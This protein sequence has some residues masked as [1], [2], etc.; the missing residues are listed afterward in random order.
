MLINS[1]KLNNTKLFITITIVSQPSKLNEEF[2]GGF[3]PIVIKMI[4]YYKND[5]SNWK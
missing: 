4:I 1:V 2:N 5:D 3:K